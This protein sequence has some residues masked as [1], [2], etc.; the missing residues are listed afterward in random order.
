M[1]NGRLLLLAAAAL[2]FLLPASPPAQAS[3][4]GAA[5]ERRIERG[6][7]DDYINGIVI[8]QTITLAGRG[9]YRRFASAWHDLAPDSLDN[10]TVYERPSARWGSLI[11]V[12]RDGKTLFRVFLRP[13]E[14]EAAKTGEAAARQVHQK[15]RELETQKLFR[16]DPDLAEDEL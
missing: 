9:F 5:A 12:E 1:L 8:D 13:N 10:L 15:L 11:W 14:A 2:A 3:A 7:S 4:N 6:I 16:S